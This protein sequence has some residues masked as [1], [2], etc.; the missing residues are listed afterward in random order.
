MLVPGQ[1]PSFSFVRD[2]S[3]QFVVQI[4]W[5]DA[6]EANA[7]YRWAVVPGLANGLTWRTPEVAGKTLTLAVRSE[8]SVQAFCVTHLLMPA[9]AEAPEPASAPSYAP[10]E[11]VEHPPVVEDEWQAVEGEYE[12]RREDGAHFILPL[13]A[14]P[15]LVPGAEVRFLRAARADMAEQVVRLPAREA[16]VFEVPLRLDVEGDVDTLSGLE[17]RAPPP[18][19]RASLVQPPLFVAR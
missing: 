19:A 16:A 12:A 2:A 13:P 15:L 3:G 6:L 9:P 8:V 18:A 10:T 14:H 7:V 1:P 17:V 11:V 5:W 4:P